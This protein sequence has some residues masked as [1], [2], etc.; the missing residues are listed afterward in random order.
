MNE[1]ERTT[2]NIE[3][4]I[5]N[6]LNIICQSE[7]MKGN[8]VSRDDLINSILKDEVNQRFKESLKMLDKM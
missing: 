2:V 7:K 4:G 5:I 3:S 6:K 1:R 8:K